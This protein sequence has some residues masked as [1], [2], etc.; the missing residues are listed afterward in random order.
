MWKQWVNG[1]LGVLIILMPNLGLTESMRSALLV[2][3]GIA[4][5]VLAFWSVSEKKKSYE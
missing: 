5:A 2:I 3:I 1:I 4:I